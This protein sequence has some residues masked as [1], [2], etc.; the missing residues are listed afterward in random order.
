[1]CAPASAWAAQTPSLWSSEA[2]VSLGTLSRGKQDPFQT[3][4]VMAQSRLLLLLPL[5]FL[6]L[7]LLALPSAPCSPPSLSL[8]LLL[9]LQLET[10][11]SWRGKVV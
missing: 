3:G 2:V 7:L 9:L 11:G 1:M 8:S 5:L 10:D 6:L 4:D